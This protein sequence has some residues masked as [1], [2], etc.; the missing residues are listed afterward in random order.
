VAEYEWSVLKECARECVP[1]I[2][3]VQN[4]EPNIT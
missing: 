4:V 2:S 1:R 3:P